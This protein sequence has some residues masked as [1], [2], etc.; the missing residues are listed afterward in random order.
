MEP[1]SALA[2]K[3]LAN[4]LEYDLVGRKMRPGSDYAGAA[5]AFR[6]AAKLDP[7]DK[8]IV[9]NL[10]ILL[11]YNDDGLR[12]GPGA[13]MQEA[14]AEYRKLTQR[15]LAD[16]GVEN[17][18]AYALFYAGEFAEARKNAETL[19]P[20]PK[21]LMVACEAA[22]NGSEAG[23]AEA[24]KCSSEDAKVKE[25]LKAAGEMLEKLRKYS[26][27]ADLLQ[28]GAAGDDT[29]STLGLAS[30]LRKAKLHEEMQFRNDPKDMAMKYLFLAMD[31]DATIEK[32]K[33]VLSKNA[34]TVLKNTLPEE[35]DKKLTYGSHH[36][37]SWAHNGYSWDINIDTTLQETEP[38]SE[39]N[40]VVGYRE[41]LQ[42]P[43]WKQMTVFVVKE[44]GQYKVL[45]TNEDCDAIGLE[46]LDRVAAHDLKGA[47]VLLDWM[48]EGQHLPGGDDPFAGQAFPRF[49]T[50]GRDADADQMRLA[51]AAILI[52]RK[53]TAQQGVPILEEARKSARS[54][55]ER[56]NI[57]F[58]LTEGYRYLAQWEKRLAIWSE[59]AR[60]FPESAT[61]LY[62]QAG[63]L[64]VLGRFGE[65][66]AIAQQRLKRLPDDI[67]AIASLENTAVFQEHYREAYDWL[68]K[69]VEAG[70]V[71]APGLNNLAWTSLFFERS[72]GPDIEAALK[73]LQLNQNNPGTLHT[74][75]CIY[76]E[77]GKTKEAYDV[78]IHA[79]DLL[80]LDEPDSNYWYAFGRIA[81]QYGEREI[82]LSDYAKVAKPKLALEIPDSTY[83]LAQIRI[84][85]LQNNPSPTGLGKD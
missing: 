45:D 48:R 35:I 49:W 68:Y 20:Q 85:V 53:P 38:K 19:N 12:Y 52:Q 42:I 24:N 28:A 32:L 37:R 60:Q 74:L 62:C 13:K 83:R 14:V 7:E 22:L 46:I 41:T 66:E 77:M 4:I 39:G 57:D 78:L 47:R 30:N 36:R 61:A 73:S 21:T 64:H 76:A 75:G 84:K 1:D 17:N 10:A 44:D 29:A 51:A 40:D 16:L 26:L 34:Q 72:Q 79:M 6:A 69:L 82:A 50:K 43:H 63:A 67:D 8:A 55:E 31:P 33:G 70:K 18:L 23:I 5:A 71:D 2:E 59:L 58:A 81:E 15:E 80:D 65:A 25:T 9:G 11:E 27:A 3:T 56:T 54:D